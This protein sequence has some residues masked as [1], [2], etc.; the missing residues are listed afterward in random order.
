MA[1]ITEADL[2]ALR[3]RYTTEEP[4]PCRVCGGV[5][6]IQSMGGGQATEWACSDRP[7]QAVNNDEWYDHY[8]RSRWTQYRSGDR[9]VLDLIAEFVRS[10]DARLAALKLIEDYE[11]QTLALEDKVYG[12]AADLLEVRAQLHESTAEASR[13]RVELEATRDDRDEARHALRECGRERNRFE[14][15]WQSARQRAGNHLAALVDSDEERDALRAELRE[16]ES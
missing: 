13:L 8:G 12:L 14:T 6:S 5:L 16:R 11:N 1:E 15:A 10:Q 9:R 7:R 4:P 2:K 3:E